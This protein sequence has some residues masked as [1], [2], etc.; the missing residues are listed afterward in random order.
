MPS[1]KRPVAFWLFAAFLTFTIV[2]VLTG[3][4]MSLAD[5][6]FTVRHGLQES[7]AL[8]SMFGVQVNRGFA[9]GDTIVYLPLVAVSLAGLCMRKRWSLI[10]T[11]GVA[12]ISAYW[13]VT[14]IFMFLFLPG[15]PGYAYVPGAEILGVVGLY[16]AAGV[17]GLVYL[18]LHGDALLR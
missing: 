1:T 10:T 6:D 14:V 8:V 2:F 16:T 13:S 15:T 4:T 7:P 12:A 18:A 5:Y 9:A 3:Q 11:A 17:C